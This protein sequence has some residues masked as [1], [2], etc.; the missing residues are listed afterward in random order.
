MNHLAILAPFVLAACAASGDLRTLPEEGRDNSLAVYLGARSLDQSD[1]EPLDDQ[2]L[3]GVEYALERS[4]ESFGF[5]AAL[6]GS[7]DDVGLFGTTREA[8]TAEVSFGLRKTFGQETVRPRLGAGI[9][10]IGATIEGGGSRDDDSSLAGYAHGGLG[11]RMSDAV[12]LGFDFRVLFGSE[13]RLE[14]QDTDADYSQFA[15]F[16]AWAF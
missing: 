4:G 12:E 5:E 15:F 1:Y 9:S 2:A 8:S 11:V 7:Y 14:G 6:L 10:F 3:F 13:L 16:V